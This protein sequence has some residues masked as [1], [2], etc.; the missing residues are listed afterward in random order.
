MFTI[1]H[2]YIIVNFIIVPTIYT[3][4]IILSVGAFFGVPYLYKKFNDIFN[5]SLSG[6]GELYIAGIVVTFIAIIISYDDPT[7]INNKLVC[8]I[9]N[10]ILSFAFFFK[11]VF[12]YLKKLHITLYNINNPNNKKG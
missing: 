8:T 3:Y 6:I 11:I 1:E 4:L 5:F 9:L 2:A 7:H 12:T 10:S